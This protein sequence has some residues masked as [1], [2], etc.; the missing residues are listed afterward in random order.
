M[1]ADTISV[2]P[3]GLHELC[4]LSHLC[5]HRLC[6][7]TTVAPA[8][9]TSP[10]L[11]SSLCPSFGLQC[12]LQ[13]S[14]YLVSPLHSSLNSNTNFLGEGFPYPPKISNPPMLSKPT[15]FYTY[16]SL[17]CFTFHSFCFLSHKTV[18]TINGEVLSISHVLCQAT[19]TRRSKPWIHNCE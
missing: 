18:N 10:P 17:I 3:Q 15:S 19:G 4:H 9:P 7:P 14:E 1:K 2:S 16:H 6:T 5:S 12:F 11:R 8:K 13:L